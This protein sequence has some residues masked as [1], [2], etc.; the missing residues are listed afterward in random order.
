ME[1]VAEE[2]QALADAANAD[3]HARGRLRFGRLA[4]EYG[5]HQYQAQQRWAHWAL[6]QLDH[7]EASGTHQ[8][9][10]GPQAR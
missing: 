2:L 1:Q 7:A 5:I 8:A 6:Q 9:P 4:I 10:D 3:S